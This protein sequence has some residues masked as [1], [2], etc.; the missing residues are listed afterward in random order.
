MATHPDFPGAT[1]RV[2]HGKVVWRYRTPG[3]AQKEIALPGVPGDPAFER[4]YQATALG[5]RVAG[6]GGNAG[7]AR[8]RLGN[9]C[10][11]YPHDRVLS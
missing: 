11:E 7:M 3:R 10:Q 2:R 8:T 5:K 9:S 6:L 1:S 4:A